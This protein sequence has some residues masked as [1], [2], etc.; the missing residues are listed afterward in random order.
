MPRTTFDTLFDV[1][2]MR[3]LLTLLLFSGIE[4]YAFKG[5]RMSLASFDPFWRKALLIAFWSTTV[6]AYG[7]IVFMM[8]NWTSRHEWQGA[9]SY[10]LFNFAVGFFIIAIDLLDTTTKRVAEEEMYSVKHTHTMY[11][12]TQPEAR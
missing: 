4:I 2:M 8:L 12:S 6:I 3:L 1:A 5:L 10:T 11:T 9:R 7:T